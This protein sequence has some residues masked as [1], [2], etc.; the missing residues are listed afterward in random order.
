[1]K[2]IGQMPMLKLSGNK[3]KKGSGCC[4]KYEP[5]CI[6]VIKDGDNPC[7]KK[8]N[9]FYTMNIDKATNKTKLELQKC[10]GCL[11]DEAK[12]KDKSIKPY[13]RFKDLVV[14]VENLNIVKQPMVLK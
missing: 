12:P 6:N 8:N 2:M 11:K 14:K 1:M 3:P 10:I 5:Y 7:G 4:K 13:E 9:K